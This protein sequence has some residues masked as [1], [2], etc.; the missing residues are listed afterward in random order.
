VPGDGEEDPAG[1]DD[2]QSPSLNLCWSWELQIL[3]YL[4]LVV[5]SEVQ[6]RYNLKQMIIISCAYSA[7]YFTNHMIR[8][9]PRN[10]FT[11]AIY[12]FVGHQSTH[13]HSPPAGHV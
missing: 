1:P 9:L 12:S 5:E 4:L 7:T 2:G 10:S 13:H 8:V 3:T 6:K 11:D